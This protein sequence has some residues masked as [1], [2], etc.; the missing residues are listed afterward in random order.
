MIG[1]RPRKVTGACKLQGV[2]PPPTPSHTCCQRSDLLVDVEHRQLLA[3]R[4]VG[5]VHERLAGL[6]G[7]HQAG[8][9]S[10]KAPDRGLPALHPFCCCA[11]GMARFGGVQGWR[12]LQ[13]G[14]QAGR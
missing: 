5:A 13:A 1:G 7:D 4:V 6:T 10:I 9:L 2:S 3:A 14:K 12:A 11:V 8:V